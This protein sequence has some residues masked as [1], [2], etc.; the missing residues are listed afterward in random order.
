MTKNQNLKLVYIKKKSVF[1]T[2]R[3][4]CTKPRKIEFSFKKL[5]FW[6]TREEKI[7]YLKEVLTRAYYDYEFQTGNLGTSVE[8]KVEKEI[9]RII[10]RNK[11]NYYYK[12]HQKH[13]KKLIDNLGKGFRE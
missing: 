4:F 2:I 11:V 10:K 3:E 8:Q 5:R 13:V 12:L 9:Q 7:A 6:K 1:D